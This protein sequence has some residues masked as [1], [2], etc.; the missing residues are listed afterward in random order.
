MGS[1]F[2][3][4]TNQNPGLPEKMQVKGQNLRKKRAQKGESQNMVP[5][6]SQVI[7]REKVQETQHKA[8][9]GDKRADQIF[10]RCLM[11]EKQ[12]LVCSSPSKLERLG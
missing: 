9:V 2:T 6:F 8:T 11:L 12:R 3:E 1:C 5:Y 10:Q 4:E 7:H